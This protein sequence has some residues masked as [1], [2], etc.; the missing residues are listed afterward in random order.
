MG[1]QD[2]PRKGRVNE[3]FKE[4]DGFGCCY[5]DV[6]GNGGAGDG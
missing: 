2:L 6:P 4:D 3:T 5:G 1:R